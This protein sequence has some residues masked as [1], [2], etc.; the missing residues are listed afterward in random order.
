[1]QKLTRYSASSA[2]SGKLEPAIISIIDTVHR[3][4]STLLRDKGDTVSRVGIIQRRFALT[5]LNREHNIFPSITV[6]SIPFYHYKHSLK[7]PSYPV[8][9]EDEVFRSMKV[10]NFSKT[11]YSDAT[12]VGKIFIYYN[13]CL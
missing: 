6:H 8:P 5:S 7:M 11:P 1:M 9:I 2:T 13:F 4:P 3:E 12:Q 10:D